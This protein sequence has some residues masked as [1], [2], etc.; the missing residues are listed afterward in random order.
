MSGIVTM[1]LIAAQYVPQQEEAGEI[2]THRM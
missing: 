2:Q 1:I